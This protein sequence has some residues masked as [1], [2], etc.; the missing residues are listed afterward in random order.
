MS[1]SLNRTVGPEGEEVDEFTTGLSPGV[2]AT[3]NK[4]YG[5]LFSHTLIFHEILENVDGFARL[6]LQHKKKHS[7]LNK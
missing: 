5:L 2:P 3:T 1:L 7:P 6:K 4:P